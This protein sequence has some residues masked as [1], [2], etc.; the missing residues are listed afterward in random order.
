MHTRTNCAA[1][2]FLYEVFT[3]TVEPTLT[4]SFAALILR[5]TVMFIF[6]PH[7]RHGCLMVGCGWS[8]SHVGLHTFKITPTI[9]SKFHRNI[10]GP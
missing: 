5:A 7:Q 9:L 3:V 8:R 10:S 4:A 1:P 2:F 6:D